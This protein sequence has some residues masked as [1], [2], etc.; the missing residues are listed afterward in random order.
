MRGFGFEKFNRENYTGKEYECDLL[1]TIDTADPAFQA[2]LKK[3]QEAAI[4]RGYRPGRPDSLPLKEAVALSKEFQPGDP[5][6]PDKAFAKELRLALAEKLGLE[7]DE[8]LD[9]LKIF[10]SLRGPLDAHGIDGFITFLCPAGES[11]EE[12]IMVSF[13]VTKNPDKDE[14]IKAAD[15]LIGGDIP[16]PSDEGYKEKDYLEIISKYAEEAA[17]VIQEKL[18]RQA[19]VRH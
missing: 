15:M 9:K 2:E 1:G 18:R 12:E 19:E 16:D 6:N 7:S 17:E 10:T 3:M 8:Q 11:G 14:P 5:T 13:D 4:R